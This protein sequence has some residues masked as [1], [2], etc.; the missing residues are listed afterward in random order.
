M[1]RTILKLHFTLLILGCFLETKATGISGAAITYQIL[2]SNLGLY[3][4]RLEYYMIC[5][6]GMFDGTQTIKII[7]SPLNTQMTAYFQKKEDISPIGLPPDVLAPINT[8][9]N[10]STGAKSPF[11]Y[12]KNIYEGNVV[13]GKNIGVVIF[14]WTDCCRDIAITNN[15]SSSNGLFVQALVNTNYPNSSPVHSKPEMIPLYKNKQ[16]I[17]NM[18]ATDIHDP[19]F[20]LVNGK[21]VVR[22]SLSYELLPSFTAMAGSATSIAN[23][24]NPPVIYETGLSASQ[25][26]YVSNAMTLNQSAA[27]VTINPNRDQL[28][29]MAY[30]VREYR[31]I[32]NTA[33]TSYTR[34]LVGYTMRD[35]VLRAEG[36]ADPVKFDGIIKDLSLVDTL[37]NNFTA[38]TCYLDNKIVF[39]AIGAPYR[40]LRIKDL[41]AI[42]PM[43]IGNYKMSY[44]LKSGNNV[45]TAYVT[46]T[47]R[48]KKE[49]PS[50][51]FLYDAYYVN[52]NGILVNNI[53]PIKV[54]PGVG[55]VQ[56]AEDTVYYCSSGSIKLDASIGVGARWSPLTSVVSI[57]ADSAI[58]ELSPTIGRWYLASNLTTTI[59]CKLHDSVYIKVLAC[60]TVYGVM[61]IDKNKNC[62]CD[63]WEY[64]IKNTS[65][66]VKGVSNVYSATVSTDSSGAYRFAPP[67]LNSYII[68]RDG[69]LFNCGINNKKSRVFSMTLFGNMKVDIPALDSVV[70]SDFN[71]GMVDTN[72]CY[73]DTV[74]YVMNFFKNYG[75]MRAIMHYGDGRVD[76][77]K[78]FDIES[79]FTSLSFS[80]QYKS[81]GQFKAKIVFL[82]FFYSPKDSILFKPV[83]ISNCIFGKVYIDGNKDCAYNPSDKL[84]A[85][86]RLDLK[87]NVSNVTDIQFTLFDGS[88]KAFLKKNEAYTLSN[89]IPI[90]CNANSPVKSIPAYTVDTSLKMDIPLD[91]LPVNYIIVV[92]K[93]GSIANNK[94]LDL[95]LSY[96]GFYIAD[97]AIKK[98]EVR[99]PAK[100]KVDALS[101]NASYT[102]SGSVLQIIQNTGTQTT[103]TLKFDSL[104]GGDNLCFFT[105]L[106]RVLPESDTSDNSQYFCLKEGESDLALNKKQVSITSQINQQDFLN[107]NDDL[108]Y[109]INFINNRTSTANQLYI[110]DIIDSK[111]DMSSMKLIKQS[112]S[113]QILFRPGNE[114][115]F[116]YKDINLPDSATNNSDSRGYVVFSF[117]PKSSLALNDIIENQAV[118]VFDFSQNIRTNTTLSRYITKPTIAIKEGPSQNSYFF[119][120]PSSDFIHL[121]MESNA[122]AS[123]RQFYLINLLGQRITLEFS[124]SSPLSKEIIL[125]VKTVPEGFYFLNTFSQRGEHIYLGKVEV[126]R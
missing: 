114:L 30:V 100:T 79:G 76:T 65:F 104:L 46:L 50:F 106:N 103:L 61:C 12:Y 94:K 14:G 55:F 59:G 49:A 87:N 28:G 70:I 23:L 84:H 109:Q 43:F 74:S 69:M 27:Q 60:D 58:I 82:D 15:K 20:I 91:P 9:C 96:S 77:A 126:R 2:D 71:T 52:T 35:V 99:L 105:R 90:M 54:I 39:K 57:S 19:K 40:S 115:V 85:Y 63:P 4:V 38:A 53:I 72:Y 37:P 124:I 25:C 41:S 78:N 125:Y 67:S 16:N 86:H 68:E 122:A 21:L 107:K 45:D 81:G 18:R 36:T 56:L 89:T 64:K 113:G 17:Y 75:L 120:N 11:G 116:A 42:D 1:K 88:Y 31:A 118:I 121:N 8:W 102:Q 48:K 93:S 101:P 80:R 108:I 98:Y 66:D 92:Q 117:K 5:A 110:S 10:P 7:G 13:I 22:D 62:L 32:P 6:H 123:H 47:Y 97:T 119:P 3:K 111:L 34:V 26:F 51:E 29:H 44:S 73:E 83:F 112:H 95:N 33:G 24:Q